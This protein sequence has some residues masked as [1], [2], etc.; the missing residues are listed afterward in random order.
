MFSSHMGIF[1]IIGYKG[2][3]RRLDNYSYQ[4]KNRK[5]VKKIYGLQY[6]VDDHHIIPKHLRTHKKILQFKYPIN[7]DFNLIMLPRTPHIKELFDTKRLQHQVDHKW[8]T[9]DIKKDIEKMHNPVELHN[10]VIKLRDGFMGRDCMPVRW[11]IE[12]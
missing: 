3:F 11:E 2:L 8:Y 9:R 4:S 7:S 5:R 10:Y 6:Y 12:K 1:F